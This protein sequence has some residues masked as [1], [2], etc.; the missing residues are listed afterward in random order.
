METHTTRRQA[1]PRSGDPIFLLKRDW[2]HARSDRSPVR[3][4][5]QLREWRGAQAL[6][7]GGL[8][9]LTGEAPAD[10]SELAR[11]LLGCGC[12]QLLATR[13]PEQALESAGWIPAPG[14]AWRA[15]FRP[16]NSTQLK[17]PAS[18]DD[19]LLTAGSVR[20][21]F[22]A[23][24]AA[25]LHYGQELAELMTAVG[26][27]HSLWTPDSCRA[28]MLEAF[29]GDHGCLLEALRVQPADRHKGC[30]SSCDRSGAQAARLLAVGSGVDHHTRVLEPPWFPA[31]GCV[32]TLPTDFLRPGLTLQAAVCA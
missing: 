11:E 2:L 32:R 31:R 27:W 1:D 13:I 21:S 24:E 8:A 18:T 6:C 19:K 20:T 17:I 23:P 25:L 16:A 7:W 12:R 9:H 30:R 10:L 4:G 29:S 5:L 28:W 26:V 15:F 14:K 3:H 22:E